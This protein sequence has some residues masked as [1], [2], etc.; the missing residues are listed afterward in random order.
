MGSS[1][2]GG[3][4]PRATT[5]HAAPSL[6]PS[7]EPS[8]SLHPMRSG[9]R[10]QPSLSPTTPPP[11][12]SSPHWDA[13]VPTRMST[14]R[15]SMVP[16]IG[17]ERSS[18]SDEAKSGEQAARVPSSLGGEQPQR[19]STAGPLFQGRPSVR[20]SMP[21]AASRVTARFSLPGSPGSPPEGSEG[22]S[23]GVGDFPEA[24]AS[25]DAEA[26]SHSAALP[27]RSG[28]PSVF[29]RQSSLGMNANSEYS[30]KPLNSKHG[31]SVSPVGPGGLLHHDMI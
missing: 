9:F 24:S 7:P 22:P 21:G 2:S 19:P 26:L 1:I 4:T 16:G 14:V 31:S 27:G 17:E 15:F 18:G 28:W 11:I 20:F 13:F 8:P 29:Q 30:P 12:G 10:R 25:P 5:P 23:T 3:S 6:S